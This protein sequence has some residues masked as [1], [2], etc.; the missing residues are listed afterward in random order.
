MSRTKQI[1]P[2]LLGIFLFFQSAAFTQTG[3]KTRQNEYKP[4][5]SPMKI[6]Q[7]IGFGMYGSVIK[8]VLGKTDHSTIEQWFGVTSNYFFSPQFSLSAS[9]AYGWVYPRNPD[10]SQFYAISHYKTILIPFSVSGRLS[11]VEDRAYSPYLIIGLG[12]TYWDVR[13]IEGTKD[14]I[15]HPGRAVNE[16]KISPTLVG[17]MG[18]E[19]FAT[20]S[21]SLDFGL[22]YSHLL[23]GDEDTIGTGDDNRGI[24]EFHFRLMYYINYDHD[25][26]GDGIPDRFDA[27]PFAP[28]DFDGFKDTD[29]IPDFDNDNDGVPDKFDKEPNIPEDK[30]GFEDDD[31]VPDLDN[32]KD[33]I[34]DK[35]DKCPN[36]AED[37]DGYEDDDGCPEADNDGDGIPDEKD[38]CPNYPE[39]VNGFE[40]LDGCPD[41][42]PQVKPK[43]EH[44]LFQRKVPLNL[45]GI[46][47]R[48]GSAE[49]TASSFEQLF[50]VGKVLLENRE[51][52]LEIRGYTDNVGAAMTN[53][54]LS[55]KRAETIK[56][57]LID[58]GIAAERL[59]AIGL[60][61][62]NPIA[63]NATTAGRAR[64]RRIEFV[65]ID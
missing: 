32:D 36:F 7:K 59:R 63:S 20:K 17:G 39:T 30:D 35:E 25:T 47:F 9:L 41:E 61:E 33:G 43:Q 6:H 54:R 15:F 29:G 10:G 44:P 62:A 18:Y 53:L 55:Q 21:V 58:H 2:M 51:I 46:N 37:F 56:R 4:R 5:I 3:N 52:R 40:D 57:F 49:L 1:L 23:K 13:D 48:S 65:R 16:S 24:V 8:M 27:D 19:I 26:D 12:A 11:L 34:P 38:K 64:N 50:K 31:G 42:K 45:P 14:S 60:G 22:R 28:E